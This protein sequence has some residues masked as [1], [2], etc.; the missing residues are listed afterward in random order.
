MEIKAAFSAFTH[1]AKLTRWDG[2]S[3]CD[4]FAFYDVPNPNFSLFLFQVH[5]FWNRFH[6]CEKQRKKPETKI[7]SMLWVSLF[8]SE[9]FSCL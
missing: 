7:Q 1:P 9:T 6:L 4:L 3:F 8:V 2:M 5:Y